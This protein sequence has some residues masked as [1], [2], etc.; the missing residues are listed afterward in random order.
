MRFFILILILFTIFAT[1]SAMETCSR[2]AIINY[3]EV[4]VDT[5]S[6]Q[7]G[8]GLRYYLEKDLIAKDY[9]NKYQDGTRLK[10][11]HAVPGSIGSALV[12]TGVLSPGDNN[13]RSFIVGGVALIL[14]NFLISKTFEAANEENLQKSIEEYNKRNLPL[15][16]FNQL[17]DQNRP[18]DSLLP[19]ILINY[20]RTF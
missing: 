5:N 2:T 12:L 10:W 14:V 19:S 17:K 15:I 4:L 8:E 7:K 18:E 6:N 3:Q 9:L 1:A 13:R 16:H 11:Y 20:S